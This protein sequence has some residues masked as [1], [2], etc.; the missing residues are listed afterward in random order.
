MRIGYILP[1][2]M[3]AFVQSAW[4]AKPWELTA[5][6]S[7]QDPKTGEFY[8]PEGN[9]RA[10]ARLLVDPVLADNTKGCSDKMTDAERADYEA[11]LK[12]EA[13]RVFKS[14]QHFKRSNKSKTTTPNISTQTVERELYIKRDKKSPIIVRD[15]YGIGSLDA[16]LAA[17]KTANGASL[18][19]TRDYKSD[20]ELTA[21]TGSVYWLNDIFPKPEDAAKIAPF[22][23]IR[24]AIGAEFDQQRNRSE[25]K[26]NIDYLSPRVVAEFDLPG[27]YFY[28]TFRLGGYYNTDSRGFSKIWGG[29]A[30]WQPLS[31][32]TGLSSGGP[33]YKNAP[34]AFQIDP[35]L[36][37]EAESVVDAGELTKVADGDRYLRAGPLLQAQF[38]FTDGPDFLQSLTFGA[39][40]RHLWGTSSGSGIQ[41]D[42]QYWQA[43]VSYNLDKDGH[44]AIKT[45]YRQGDLPGTGQDVRDLKTGLSIK[46]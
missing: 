13:D 33:L 19:Y 3:L 11:S 44:A 43:N 5:R 10:L 8:V 18:T 27:G 15:A 9:E 36:H 45:T 20:N 26:K 1:A 12:V 40:Y 46:Y 2:L 24:W 16:L 38:W 21:S 6:C 23:Q 17:K 34:I 7:V 37:L 4:A 41:R 30:E 22:D 42:L 39:Q 29:F 25:P 31:V 14:I 32:G 28:H 35:I